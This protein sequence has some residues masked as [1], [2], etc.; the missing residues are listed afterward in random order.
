MLQNASN[1]AYFEHLDLYFAVGG[2]SHDYVFF[3]FRKSRT[4]RSRSIF[5]LRI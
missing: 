3:L 1:I 2:F 5:E 4:F